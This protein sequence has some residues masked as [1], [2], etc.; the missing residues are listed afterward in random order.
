M[1][2]SNGSWSSPSALL[3]AHHHVAIHLDEPAVAIPREPLVLR[4]P[5]KRL[6]CLIVQA[7]VQDCV[8]LMPGIESRAP[9]R[10]AT[11]SGMFPVSPN[12]VPMIRSMLAMPF[13][14]SAWSE[15]G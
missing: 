8:H 6:H 15:G 10:T 11:S 2:D 4:R 7:E 9:E 13:S 5:D 1:T 14:T 3:H 12:F